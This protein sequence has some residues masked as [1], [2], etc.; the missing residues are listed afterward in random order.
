MHF[1]S[2]FKKFSFDKFNETFFQIFYKL[3][4]VGKKEISGNELL[5]TS[6]GAYRET[7]FPDI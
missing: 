1:S 4:V 5:R 3:E 6:R 2:S 7:L